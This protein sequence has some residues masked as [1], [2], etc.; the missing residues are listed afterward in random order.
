MNIFTKRI[1]IRKQKRL[2]RKSGNRT[3]KSTAWPGGFNGYHHC[4]ASRYV[5][6]YD[7]GSRADCA[8]FCSHYF[9][10]VLPAWACIRMFPETAQRNGGDRDHTD[11]TAAGVSSV[12]ECNFLEVD[13]GKTSSDFELIKGN[14]CGS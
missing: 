2:K 4:G 5:L 12:S 6:R 9:C 13:Y 8:V 14:G 11:H 1:Q 7:P 10:R 3:N